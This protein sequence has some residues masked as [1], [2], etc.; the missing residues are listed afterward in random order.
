MVDITEERLP[1]PSA[2]MQV[3]R[4][5]V[6]PAGKRIIRVHSD[7]FAGDAFN[8][9]IGNARFSPLRRADGSAIPTLYG[10]V[11]AEVAIM[12]S[13]FHDVPTGSL[14][15]SFDL[16][17]A[18]GLCISTLTP[19]GT[20]SLVSLTPTLLR[21]WGVTQAALTA[22]SPLHYPQTRQWA[23]AIYNANPHLHGISWPSRQHGGKALMLFGDRLSAVPLTLNESLPLLEGALI[24]IYRLADEM[25]L[26]LT[27]A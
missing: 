1:A 15:V 12:E 16:R 9:G 4:V 14:G 2:D 21:R 3:P 20:L 23:A 6:W 19:R 13:L 5:T 8:P 17:K 10:G 24:E 11:G 27:E 18:A 22:S 25:G 7:K 26:V